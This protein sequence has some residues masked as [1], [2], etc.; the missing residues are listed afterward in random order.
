M[1][2]AFELLIPKW[3]MRGNFTVPKLGINLKVYQSAS[4]NCDV[5]GTWQCN[6]ACRLITNQ[7][8]SRK[9]TERGRRF[10]Y[11]WIKLGCGEWGGV[12]QDE[13]PG[14]GCTQQKQIIQNH[15]ADTHKIGNNGVSLALKLQVIAQQLHTTT[16]DFTL[17]LSNITTHAYWSPHQKV[18]M[19]VTVWLCASF[20]NL[21]TS[22]CSKTRAISVCTVLFMSECAGLIINTTWLEH[23]PNRDETVY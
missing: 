15:D 4:S 5:T 13:V 17:L 7:N 21:I 14:G 6:N 20:F 3:P 19:C 23:R 16:V 12:E 8:V 22:L 18:M 11:S 10:V 1:I 2:N 9:R